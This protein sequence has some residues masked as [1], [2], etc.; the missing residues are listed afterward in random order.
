MDNNRTYIRKIIFGALGLALFVSSGISF[1]RSR[2]LE[3]P[4]VAGPGVTGV[5][6]LHEY[7]SG[8]KDTA[9]DCNIYFLEGKK[10]G[11]TILVLGGTHPEEPAGRLAAWLMAENAVMEQGR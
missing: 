8:I 2:H 6:R 9:N 10:G 11:A 7:F 3:E 4:V 5:K 1:Y